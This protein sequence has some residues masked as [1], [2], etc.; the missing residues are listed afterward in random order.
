MLVLNRPFNTG[1]FISVADITGTIVSM[2]LKTT[3]VRTIDGKM[4]YIPNS[5]IVN[6]PLTN[7]TIEGKRR[8][9]FEVELDVAAN[10]FCA[11]N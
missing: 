6:S 10:T 8:F 7:Y 9:E 1:D 4:I 3:D 11:E 2:D 5:M